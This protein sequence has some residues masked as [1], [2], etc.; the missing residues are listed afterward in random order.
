MHS[1][2]AHLSCSQV[3]TGQTAWESPRLPAIKL[4][5]ITTSHQEECPGYHGYGRA[6]LWAKASPGSPHRSPQYSQR[7][8]ASPRGMVVHWISQR[9]E[10]LCPGAYLS[11]EAQVGPTWPQVS[12]GGPKLR[13]DWPQR[14]GL[15]EGSRCSWAGLTLIC[16]AVW[17]A[18]GAW[19][20]GVPWQPRPGLRQ[21]P[22]GLPSKQEERVPSRPLGI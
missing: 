4:G 8:Q 20:L 15:A 11:T 12:K 19:W 5:G 13:K 1:Y 6:Q 17:R 3:E 22:Q 16:L 9:A 7:S 21:L 2:H 18:A 10:V 14:G